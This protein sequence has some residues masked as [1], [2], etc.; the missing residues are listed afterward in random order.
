MERAASPMVRG[1]Q[2]PPSD[3]QKAT[4]PQSSFS[5]CL[6]HRFLQAAPT[7]AVLLPELVTSVIVT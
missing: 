5:S 4:L 7:S 3:P 2:H 1:P 6:K